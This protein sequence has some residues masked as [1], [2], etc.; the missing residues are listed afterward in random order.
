MGSKIAKVLETS[1]QELLDIGLRG[2]T[3]LNFRPNNVH[4]LAIIDEVS[5]EIYK[6]LG[7]YIHYATK[8]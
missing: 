4:S 7:N 3:L 2:N 5:I 8:I 1:R 6:I